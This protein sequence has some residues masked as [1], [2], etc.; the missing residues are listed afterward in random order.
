VIKHL[1]IFG[2]AGDLTSRYLMPALGRLIAADSIA[3]DLAILGA[4]REDW[5]TEH[6]RH[7]IGVRLD[8]HAADLDVTARESLLERLE[9]LRA[10]VTSRTT[11]SSSSAWWAWNR[12]SP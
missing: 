8:E 4:S 3:E 5:D 7:H 9:Y 10:D 12:R 2:A 11:C 1:V 6:F